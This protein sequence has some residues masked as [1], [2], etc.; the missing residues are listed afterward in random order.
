MAFLVSGK[1]KFLCL[2]AIQDEVTEEKSSNLRGE[3][4]ASK[5]WHA[6]KFCIILT[7][8]GFSQPIRNSKEMMFK[9]KI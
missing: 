4:K 5:I 1:I 3:K 8:P 7:T 9:A 6:N 2:F